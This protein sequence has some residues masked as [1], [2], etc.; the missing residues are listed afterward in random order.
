M[1]RKQQGNRPIWEDGNKHH[2]GMAGME[3]AEKVGEQSGMLVVP[4]G[5]PGKQARPG[6]NLHKIK[7]GG[8]RSEKRIFGNGTQE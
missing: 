2:S 4:E 5:T 7:N 8:E 3:R 1:D 6:G